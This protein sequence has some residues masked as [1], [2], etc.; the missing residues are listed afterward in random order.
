M[1]VFLEP[2]VTVASNHRPLQSSHAQ[3]H[4]ALS[5]KVFLEPKV[6]VAPATGQCSQVTPNCIMRLAASL[7]AKVQAAIFSMSVRGNLCCAFS[8]S[9]LSTSEVS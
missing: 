2:K 4:E 9:S 3:L 8:F 1:K 6:T 7:D 5:V